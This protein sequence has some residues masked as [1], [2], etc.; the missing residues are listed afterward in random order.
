M[1]YQDNGLPVARE[2]WPFAV[3]LL[4][5][6]IVFGLVGFFPVAVGLSVLLV[7]V[8]AFFR[9]PVRKAP[10]GGSAIV[11]P[12]DGRVVAAGIVECPDFPDGQALR[13]AVFMSLLNVHMNWAP[14]AG[15]VLTS[16]HFPGRFLNAMEDKASVENERKVLRME[17]DTGARVVV[18]L[19]AGLV[20]RRIVCPARE[21][22][23]LARGEK[24]G[25]IRFGSRVEVLVPATSELNVRLNMRVRGGETVVA[26]MPEK[27]ARGGN[28]S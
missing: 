16:E 13:I 6:A 27:D 5:A 11:A 17:H 22:D 21:G 2:A 12:A 28:D 24:I 1:K 3:P 8:L 18:K 7:A 15:K 20:A 25:M 26:R 19:V 14:C 10:A 9:N 23:V 4:A